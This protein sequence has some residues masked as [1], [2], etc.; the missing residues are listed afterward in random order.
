[1][2]LVTLTTSFCFIVVVT[3]GGGKVITA[4]GS[5][6]CVVIALPSVDMEE[7]KG[8]MPRTRPTEIGQIREEKFSVVEE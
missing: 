4:V 5:I 3:S 2:G 8:Q 7:Q 6:L 1:M